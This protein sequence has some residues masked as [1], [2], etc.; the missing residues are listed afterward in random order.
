MCLGVVATPWDFST[1]AGSQ[2]QLASESPDLT[3]LT[4]FVASLFLIV[5]LMFSGPIYRNLQYICFQERTSTEN[6]QKSIFELWGWNLQMMS[7]HAVG[8]LLRGLMMEGQ[9]LIETMKPIHAEAESE[10]APV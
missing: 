4:K 2:A 8:F 1:P 7:S 6:L 3:I 10:I 9:R 5:A